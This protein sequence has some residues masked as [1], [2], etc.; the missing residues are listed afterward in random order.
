MTRDLP[1]FEA[2]LVTAVAEAHDTSPD[3]LAA[4]VARVQSYLA[5]FPGIEDLVYEWKR[6]FAYDPVVLRDD[7]R[8]VVV[9]LP[10]VW[11]ELAEQLELEDDDLATL[12]AVHD[13]QARATFDARGEDAAVLEG[14]APMVLHRE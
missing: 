13:R 3:Q 5:G 10:Y 6:A 9:L 11:E 12:R 1:V 8:Y 4:L 14:G 7:E 2:E